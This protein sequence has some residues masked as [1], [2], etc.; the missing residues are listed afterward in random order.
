MKTFTTIVVILSLILVGSSIGNQN[1]NE[2]I[3]NSEPTS[4]DRDLQEIRSENT[5]KAITTYSSTN[6]FLYRGRPMGYQYELLKR[7]SEHLD[8]DLEI[9][10]AQDKNQAFELLQLGEGDL[11][12]MGLTINNENKQK[13]NFSQPLRNT[14]YVLVQAMPYNWH[15]LKLHEIE[16]L[17]I[18]DP[19][20]LKNNKIHVRSNSA[21]YERLK[22]MEDELGISLNI[23]IIPQDI[24]TYEILEKVDNGEYELAVVD[25]DEAEIN[26]ADFEDL[27]ASTS[28]SLPVR[29][30]WAVRKNSVH[31][32]EEVDNWLKN[33][34]NGITFN[35]LYN[36]YFKNRRFLRQ[37][38]DSEFY[39]REGEK[40]SPFDSLIKQYSGDYDWRFLASLIYQESNFKKDTNSWVGA[41]G[42]MQ[43]MPTTA[44]E[45]GVTN[46]LDP[47][48][49][50]SAGVEYLNY[51]M[52]YWQEIPDSV[53][54]LK[55]SLA[56][57]N[58]GL[59]HVLDAK[60]L[61]EKYDYNS[62]KW[63][64]NVEVFIRKLAEPKYFTDPVVKYG[65]CRGSEPYNYVRDILGR[66]DHY[67]K[68][69]PSAKEAQ[70]KARVSSYE[71]VKVF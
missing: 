3:K 70:L 29:T 13:V 12:A 40:I 48:Q 51:L 14:E 21:H 45:F 49:N 8:L 27:D 52:N 31:F 23:Q 71:P 4:S 37:R 22:N 39:S 24:T 38:I 17:L 26:I 33:V 5:L 69:I 64:E 7:F 57:Y 28:I 42:L 66:Y 41:V 1:D 15:A 65:Y 67:K 56:S 11:I 61:A 63:D 55:F 9:I 68:F 10:V 16:D 50:I 47:E 19:Y 18:R 54:R 25:Q 36:K 6:Y 20:E 2:D 32:L 53:D 59:A 35:V 60:R 44:R 34:N 58:C 62:N 43:L 46:P 30:G